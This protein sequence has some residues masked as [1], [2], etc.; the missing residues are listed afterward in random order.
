VGETNAPTDASKAPT[1]ATKTPTDEPTTSRPTQTGE[2]REPTAKPTPEDTKEPTTRRPTQTGETIEPTPAT[3][4]PTSS[5]PTTS[6][7]TQKGETL[8]PTTSRPTRNGETLE[9][10]QAPT[11]CPLVEREDNVTADCDLKAFAWTV[12]SC[13]NCHCNNTN[14]T[15][16]SCAATVCEN[17]KQERCKVAADNFISCYKAEAEASARDAYDLMLGCRSVVSVISSGFMLSALFSV[18]ASSAI[19]SIL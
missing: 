6:R 7:P 9:P 4:E 13:C 17:Y 1:D 8:E 12:C 5:E 18:L 19:I 15:I 14:T 10:T 2:T 3:K 16:I 11:I